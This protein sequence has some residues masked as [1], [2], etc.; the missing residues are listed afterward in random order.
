MVRSWEKEIYR[1]QQVKCFPGINF[2]YREEEREIRRESYLIVG[3]IITKTS[4]R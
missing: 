2:A 3:N 1:N 4:L